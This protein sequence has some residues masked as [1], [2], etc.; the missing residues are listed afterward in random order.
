MTGQPRQTLT[1]RFPTKDIS[2]LASQYVADLNARD[3][4]LTQVITEEVFPAYESQ[5]FL[6]KDQCLKVCEWKSPRTKPL[7]ESNDASFIR[8]VSA[9]ARTTS[10]EQMRIQV[11]TLLKGINW[12][13]ASVFVH[14][15]FFGQY[16]ILDVRAL[17]SLGV[18]NPPQ[19]DFTF[20]WNYT[21][22]C[23]SLAAKAGGTMRELDQALW[24]YSQLNQ[25]RE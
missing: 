16:P 20:W 24:K 25:S 11:W 17:W 7:V 18:E 6:T 1:L 2:E 19:Y 22:A 5:G 10:S 4:G 15:A 12:A 14:F 3:R 23:R 13:T 9:L 21:E 8:E